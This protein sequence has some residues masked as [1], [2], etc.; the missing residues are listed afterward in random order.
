[1]LTHNLLIQQINKILY[2]LENNSTNYYPGSIFDR[3][4]ALSNNKNRPVLIN[5]MNVSQWLDWLINDPYSNVAI[6]SKATFY[7]NLENIPIKEHSEI[8]F[9]PNANI[10]N[11]KTNIN[12]N[13]NW[14]KLSLFQKVIICAPLTST[15][16]YISETTKFIGQELGLI[17]KQSYIDPSLQYNQASTPPV[18]GGGFNSSNKYKNKYI[19][20]KSKYIDLKKSRF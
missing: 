2:G 8:F 7:D 15:R 1:M 3:P 16:E 11:I 19:K 5:C 20:Y 14:N 9:Y 6:L 10:Q 17:K 4:F 18:Q 13:P 12:K